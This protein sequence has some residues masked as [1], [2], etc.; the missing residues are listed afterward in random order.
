M[1]WCK[2]EQSQLNKKSIRLF[3]SKTN[4]NMNY[5]TILAS[6]IL[7]SFTVNAQSWTQRADYPAEARHHPVCFSIGNFGYLT[8]GV[9]NQSFV[10]DDFMRYDIN[11]DQWDTL[12]DFPG[13]ARGLAVGT[14]YNGL[15][16]VGFGL[17]TNGVLDD[18][19]EYDPSTETWTE[20]A[21]CP[22]SGRAHPALVATAGKIYVGL[23]D[24]RNS[25]LNDWWEYDIATDTW[26]Q[27]PNFPGVAR[28]HPYYFAIGDSAYVGFGHG[29]SIYK[30]WYMYDPATNT[31]EQKNDLPDQGRVAG[32]QFSYGG[33]GYVIAG[34]NENHQN[35]GFDA[36]FWEYDPLADSWAQ[37][38][39]VPVG[40]SRWAP[41][42]FVIDSS[43]FFTSGEKSEREGGLSQN[44][45]WHY[46][47]PSLFVPPADTMPD[48]M[49]PIT[50]I[51]TINTDNLFKLY[52][53]PTNGELTV[54]QSPNS[55]E[56]IVVYSLQG[57]IVAEQT[58]SELNRLNLFDKPKGLY[59][60]QVG[61]TREK[62]ILE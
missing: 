29:P 38:P 22:C 6:I 61:A 46:P 20:L 30:D 33:K 27:R 25:N 37:L 3:S 43:L 57:K 5:L 26:T 2:K 24:D 62:F 11:T 12:P 21:N 23:G 40:D 39:S 59:I 49:P 1:W 54:V 55:I 31:W 8:T 50:S 60:I 44:D 17:T 36:E 47:L 32:T 34:E 28:H 53:N 35:N 9:S 48:T 19:W 52:P 42:S 16:Y 41:G 10:L 14:Q 51:A 58:G 15:G 56:N 13:A 45:V 4:P 18:L 7:L